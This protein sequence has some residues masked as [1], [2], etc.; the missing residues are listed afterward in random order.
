MNLYQRNW[1]YG[2]LPKFSGTSREDVIDFFEELEPR[3]EIFD[4]QTKSDCL[5]YALRGRAKD[6]INYVS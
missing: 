1:L 6:W 5:R 3:I 4:D 2:P